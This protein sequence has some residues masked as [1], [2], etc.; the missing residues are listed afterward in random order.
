MTR[1]PFRTRSNPE[2]KPD[3]GFE[4][5]NQNF[6]FPVSAGGPLLPLLA[7]PLLAWRLPVS[8]FQFPV[9]AG[10]PCCRSLLWRLP[11][12]GFSSFFLIFS[13]FPKCSPFF[14]IFPH[15]PHFSPF[16]LIFHHFGVLLEASW[17]L[18][19]WP[20]CVG[21]GAQKRKPR[22]QQQ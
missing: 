2:S 4:S 20:S 19:V 14:P 1:R 15:F 6:R 10:V 8:G 12:S 16:F 7:C 21:L 5:R 3:S 17:E 11:I 22:K 13:I 18:W 9:S